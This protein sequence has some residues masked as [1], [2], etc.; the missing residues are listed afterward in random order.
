MK[1]NLPI[2]V[3]SDIMSGSPVFVGTRVPVESLFTYL[4]N[5]ESLD[6]FL[7]CFPSIKREDALAI[8][9]RVT[10][11]AKRKNRRFSRSVAKR[12]V[13]DIYLLP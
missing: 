5:G 11:Q 1:T 6:G 10:E 13:G 8:L 9:E 3:D 4:M 12:R 2:D 7:A